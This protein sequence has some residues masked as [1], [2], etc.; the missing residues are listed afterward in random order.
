MCL[1][2]QQ[3]D[4]KLEVERP[5]HRIRNSW[6]I[7]GD[8]R[9]K[10][11]IIIGLNVYKHSMTPMMQENGKASKSLFMSWSQAARIKTR[12]N[13]KPWPEIR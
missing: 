2:I 13:S 12:N 7:I 6:I 8:K 11:R 9:S 3:C 4:F 5:I 10:G 1:N